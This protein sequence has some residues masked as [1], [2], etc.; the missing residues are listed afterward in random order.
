MEKVIVGID[1]GKKGAIA[2]LRED[3]SLL[4][5]YDMPLT[6]TGKGGRVDARKL[7][8]MLAG[9]CGKAVIEKVGYVPGDG[10][11]AA[12][13]FGESAGAA[14][15]VLEALG[16]D[17]ILVRPQE[18]RRLHCLKGADNHC[19]RLW[20]RPRRRNQDRRRTCHPRSDLKFVEHTGAA[21]GAG[22]QSLQDIEIRMQIYGY[23]MFANR[24]AAETATGRSLQAN[25]NNSQISEVAQ[26]LQDALKKAF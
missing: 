10:G 19:L 23:E 13:S 16:F 15:G 21:I 6:A 11:L 1:P 8:G 18:G 3:G 9:R 2:I 25:E 26:S 12:F 22:R 20:H 17:T 24:G 5:L 4:H 14:R 7:A